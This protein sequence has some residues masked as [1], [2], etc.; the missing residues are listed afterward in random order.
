M[1][2]PAVV[3]TG[4]G[5][6]GR[7]VL[8]ALVRRGTEVAVLMRS[9]GRRSAAQRA[10][11]LFDTLSLTALERARVTVLVGDIAQPE[12]GLDQ[13][14]MTWLTERAVAVVHTA[15]V[16]SL[17]ADRELCDSVNRGG[18]ANV[19]LA[20]HEW[21]GRGRLERFVHVS[22]A[23]AAGA[24]SAGRVAEGEL[25]ARAEFANDYERS[26]NDGERL[27]RAA[28]QA[29]LPAAILRP[30]MVVGDTA[31]GW[32]RDFNVIYPL[33]R[34]MASGYV[35]RFPADPSAPVHLAPID[36]AVRAIV[37]ALDVPWADGLTFNVT[38][39]APPTVGELFGCEAFFRLG[40]ARP[41]LCP[42]ETFDIEALPPRERDTLETLAFC[43]PYFNSRLSFETRNAQ[44]LAGTPVT[45]AAYL[46]RLG[47]FA[48]ASGYL[49]P[50]CSNPCDTC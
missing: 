40:I 33:I 16:T 29:G 31:T 7:E 35:G 27:V 28:M 2:A 34:A 26:K 46:E 24:A 11:Q 9:R 39:P 13:S 42:P 4:V 8:L 15:A 47:E 12:C 22:T 5:T 25:P 32:T 19:L 45:D 17:V 3:L 10:D 14:A 44:R 43:F 50:W 30:S 1:T 37:A 6:V 20:A 23:L 21:H 38:A 18:T 41:D 48:V 36:F 49:R